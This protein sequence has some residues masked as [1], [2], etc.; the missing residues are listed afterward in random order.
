VLG[1]GE[2]G[3]VYLS[4]DMGCTDFDVDAITSIKQ[5]DQSKNEKLFACK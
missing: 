1:K 3:E 4:K 5:I 2:F